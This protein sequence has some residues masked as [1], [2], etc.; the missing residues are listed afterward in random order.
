[1]CVAIFIPFYYSKGVVIEEAFFPWYT[2]QY[3][4]NKYYTCAFMYKSTTSLCNQNKSAGTVET[5]FIQE[6]VYRINIIYII[7]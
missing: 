3:N 4:N 2:E 1:M 6:E 7:M 5:L